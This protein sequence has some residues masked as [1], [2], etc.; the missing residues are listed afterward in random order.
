[1]PVRSPHPDVQIPPVSL[2]EFLF[3]DGFG[4]HAGSAA[5]VDGVTGASLTF[6]ELHEQ[7]LR[8]AAALAERGVGRGDVVAVFAPNS[9]WWPVVFHGVL[10]ANA[11][12]T[13]VNVLN[14]AG[15]VAAQL[16]DAGARMLVTT[17]AL[18]DRAE[19]AAATAGLDDDAVVVLDGAPGHPSGTRPA[20]RHRG[21]AAARGRPGGHGRA[22][23]LL[24]DQ[25]A[26]EG[27]DP[28]PPQPG[29]EPR[30]GPGLRTAGGPGDGVR[31]GAADVP[32]LRRIADEPGDP[33]APHRRHA[34][35][36]RPGRV[37]AHGGAVPAAAA[38]PGAADPA[39]AGQAPGRRLLRPVVGGDRVLRGGAAG[40]RA[41]PVRSR[42]GWAAGSCRAT[43]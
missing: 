36:V 17:A 6:G 29:G 18:L 32:H 1:M 40:C 23:L 30:A 7:V 24:G 5:F 12:V 26:A 43:A 20:R 16:A 42:H 22:A 28:H 38:P 14:T 34:P 27:G 10:R 11:V 4:E 21:P 8:V 9:P 39:R 3:A 2:W 31:R 13:T 37:P 15:D 35:A 19:A 41:R 25:R 33:P